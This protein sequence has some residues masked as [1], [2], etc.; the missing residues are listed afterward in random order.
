MESMKQINQK[1]W[2]AAGI[3]FLLPICSS[4][5]EPTIQKTNNVQ[6]EPLTVTSLPTDAYRSYYE[7]FPYSF[8]DSKSPKSIRARWSRIIWINT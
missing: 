8:A 4:C 3:A 2:L 6:E 5:S 1:K 7:I